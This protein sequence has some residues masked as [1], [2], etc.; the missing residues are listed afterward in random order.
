MSDITR[1][2]LFPSYTDLT[3]GLSISKSLPL[4]VFQDTVNSIRRQIVRIYRSSRNVR[5]PR[6]SRL[7][8]TIQYVPEET[9]V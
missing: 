6:Q 9:P 7:G 8:P 3:G 2:I 4:L 1:Y 5:I